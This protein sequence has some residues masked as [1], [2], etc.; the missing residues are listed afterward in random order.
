MH[1]LVPVL[2]FLLTTAAAQTPP[3]EWQTDFTTARQLAAGR[4][5]PLFVVFRCER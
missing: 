4:H 5:A 3:I 1:R 2:P